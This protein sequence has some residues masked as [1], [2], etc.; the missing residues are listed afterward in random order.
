MERQSNQQAARLNWFVCERMCI[1]VFGFIDKHC[2]TQ[3]NNRISTKLLSVLFRFY[4]H[5]SVYHFANTI[6]R[7]W[8][9]AMKTNSNLLARISEMFHQK[10]KLNSKFITIIRGRKK[11]KQNGCTN[12]YG[13]ICFYLKKGNFYVANEDH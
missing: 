7:T 3:Y 6:I 9:I 10:L 8:S 4:S 11:P 13:S 1:C 12:C 5:K 2:F